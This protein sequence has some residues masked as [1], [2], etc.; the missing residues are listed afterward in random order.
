MFIILIL[1]IAS[2]YSSFMNC[3]AETLQ[4]CDDLYHPVCAYGSN[5]K[6]TKQFQNSCEACKISTTLYYFEG[7]CQ[8][9]INFNNTFTYRSTS[10][11]DVQKEVTKYCD[12]KTRY[13]TDC[14][15]QEN[16]VCGESTTNCS[17]CQQE[18][19]NSC[20]A[21]ANSAVTSYYDGYCRNEQ[22]QSRI[23]YCP[24][25]R[26]TSCNENGLT[27]CSQTTSPCL[28][29]DCYSESKSW[30]AACSNTD[31]VTYYQG[32]CQDYLDY[33]QTINIMEEVTQ[34]CSIVK[35]ETCPDTVQE[36]CATENC[37]DDKL[38][39]LK[40]YTN[41]CLACQNPKVMSYLPFSCYSYQV[42]IWIMIIY[43]IY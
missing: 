34:K 16:L 1:C 40:T 39:C 3:P 29:Q 13:S 31:V 12:E 18:Y 22:T 20:V 28:T 30:C 8:Q 9:L 27:V 11:Q 32:S 15:N 17:V 10:E 43:F 33:I 19:S 5:E 38:T 24:P 2:T 36:V 25:N 37:D 23:I 42:M 14:S 35:P 4:I 7:E 6:I 21:C 41:S 26:P